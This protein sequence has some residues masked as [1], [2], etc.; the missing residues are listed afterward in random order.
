MGKLNGQPCPSLGQ[1]EAPWVPD[2][3]LLKFCRVDLQK[4]L[5]EDDPELN[6]MLSPASILYCLN[7][8]ETVLSLVGER[9]EYVDGALDCLS[10]FTRNLGRQ[11]E[12]LVRL[13][14][15]GQIEHE[16]PSW[17]TDMYVSDWE[18]AKMEL[19]MVGELWPDK[20]REEML[21]Q[22]KE[23]ERR[24]GECEKARSWF[25][26]SCWKAD[27]DWA[28]PQYRHLFKL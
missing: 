23:F 13:S 2:H 20:L 19:A 5:E 6:P 15:T 18:H 21:E 28:H 10:M 1:D 17:V 8:K 24:I 9:T 7:D 26:R 12:E 14:E 4:V 22:V 27:A 11:A 3:E 25:Y 16:E